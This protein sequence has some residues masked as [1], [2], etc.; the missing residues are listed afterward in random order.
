MKNMSLFILKGKIRNS[1][2]QP[3]KSE[4][5]TIFMEET[6]LKPKSEKN[7][8]GLPELFS[9]NSEKKIILSPLNPHFFP[10]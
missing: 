2:L 6:I 1:G 10:S 5:K 7:L 9:K 8:K 3:G 4:Q